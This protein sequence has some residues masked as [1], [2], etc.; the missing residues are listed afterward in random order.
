MSVESLGPF[1]FHFKVE[2]RKLNAKLFQPMEKVTFI[3]VSP[4]VQL[5]PPSVIWKIIGR[6]FLV[7]FM[8]IQRHHHQHSY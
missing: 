8:I 7:L 3:C 5:V 2:P 4:T 6:D 1:R